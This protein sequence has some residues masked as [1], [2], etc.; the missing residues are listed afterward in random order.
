MDRRKAMKITAGVIAGG[1][2]GL[3]TI[4]KAF[5]TRGPDQAEPQ[6]LEFDSAE[7]SWKYTELDP[8]VSASLAYQFYSRYQVL[9]E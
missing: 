8:S 1:G 3:F 2:A 6:N 7:S 9:F 5:K 4:S